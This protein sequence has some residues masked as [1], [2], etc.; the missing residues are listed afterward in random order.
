MLL[1]DIMNKGFVPCSTDNYKTNMN[2]QSELLS[3]FFS[4]KYIV[5][6]V[7]G[8]RSPLFDSAT[9]LYFTS[10]DNAS[11]QELVLQ[12]H[13]QKLYE[14]RCCYKKDTLHVEFKHILQPPIY[15]III[16]N[17][18]N[19]ISNKIIK[20]RS[21]IPLDLNIVL[22]PYKFNL[23]A[24][25]T[26]VDIPWSMAIILSLSIA[27]EKPFIVPILELMNTTSMINIT[28]LLHIYYVTH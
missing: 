21:L 3:S 1:I 2:F 9:I 4:D 12:E 7:C 20:N 8:L 10:T 23:R 25:V 14:A 17:R 15:V 13:K 28:Y 18:F 6:D 11:L 22:G 24:T 27:V 26:I 5:C 19:Y 16:V